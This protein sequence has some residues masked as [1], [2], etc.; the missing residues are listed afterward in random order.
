MNF[1]IT[2]SDYLELTKREKA[3]IMKAWEDKRVSESE[4]IRNAVLNAVNNAL[5]KKGSKFV[6]LWKRKQQPADME[7]VNA[8][9]EIIQK[10]EEKEG[11]SW[12]DM[13]YRA[14]NLKKPQRE[15]E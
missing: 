8:H 14:N 11:K 3:F 7:I 9:L 2:K 4:L 15:E 6:D 10:S 12:V 1:G 5:R 13:I